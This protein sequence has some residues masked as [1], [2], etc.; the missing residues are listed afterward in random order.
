MIREGDIVRAELHGHLAYFGGRYCPAEYV[1]ILADITPPIHAMAAILSSRSAPSMVGALREAADRHGRIALVAAEVPTKEGHIEFLPAQSDNAKLDCFAKLLPTFENGQAPAVEVAKLMYGDFGAIPIIVH[2]NP[3]GRLMERWVLG[4]GIPKIK[5]F[6]FQLRDE[7]IEVPIGVE[8][9]SSE[10]DRF[11]GPHNYKRIEELDQIIDELQP[12]GVGEVGGSD[13]HG[14]TLGWAHTQWIT[15]RNIFNADDLLQ[16]FGEALYT[17]YQTKA[18]ENMRV[19]SY[20][21]WLQSLFILGLDHTIPRFERFLIDVGVP[22]VV[23]RRMDLSEK[24]CILTG[25]S[26]EATRAWRVDLRRNG[27][28]SFADIYHQTYQLFNLEDKPTRS[29]ILELQP[30]SS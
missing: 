5:S 10:T 18:V 26:S 14:H 15:R 12:Y 17:P 22:R 21:K 9:Y 3:K 11:A 7:D 1:K 29:S 8:K 19:T 2:A 23:V 13:E 24:Y 30:T 27:Q 6:V 20:I 28:Q 25:Q 4:M 16:S